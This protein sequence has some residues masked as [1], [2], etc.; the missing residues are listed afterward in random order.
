MSM[1]VKRLKIDFFIFSEKNVL[2]KLRNSNIVDVYENN[3][4]KPIKDDTTVKLIKADGTLRGTVF[5]SSPE[6]GLRKSAMDIARQIS[7]SDTNINVENL[8]ITDNKIE[9]TTSQSKSNP[10]SRRP[11]STIENIPEN[12]PVTKTGTWFGKNPQ[13]RAGVLEIEAAMLAEKAKEDEA[14]KALEEATSGENLENEISN[15]A[16]PVI[17]VSRSGASRSSYRNATESPPVIRKVKMMSN[18]YRRI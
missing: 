14:M 6:K 5:G 17:S 16:S 1:G 7:Q 15:T 9:E 3:K 4:I 12:L 10:A 8:N 18:R 11:S 13:I 2:I